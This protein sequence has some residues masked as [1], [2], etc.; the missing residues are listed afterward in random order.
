MPVAVLVLVPDS[1]AADALF[2]GLVAVFAA[3]IDVAVDSTSVAER[4]GVEDEALEREEPAPWLRLRLLWARTLN[5]EASNSKDSR[6]IYDGRILAVV[7]SKLW[8]LWTL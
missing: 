2:A 7:L 3:L 8:V 6:E 5:G 1:V 4:A